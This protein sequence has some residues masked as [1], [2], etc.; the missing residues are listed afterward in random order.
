MLVPVLIA[1]VLF[2]VLA[3]LVIA[4]VMRRPQ[5]ALPP[6]PPAADG[7]E[8]RARRERQEALD[9][10]GSQ[11]IERRVELD[12]RRGTLGGDVDLERSLDELYQRLEAGEISEQ[13]FEAEKVRLLGG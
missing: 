6:A 10:R 7:E 3:A 5:P 1:I 8:A 12:A 4:I 9:T 2:L 13:E 11:L